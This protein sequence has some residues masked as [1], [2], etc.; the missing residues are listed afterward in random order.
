MTA[1]RFCFNIYI[2]LLWFAF[3]V[4]LHVILVSMRLLNAIL[5]SRRLL[6]VLSS[7]F[8]WNYPQVFHL[9]Q[10]LLVV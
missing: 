1:S 8:L 6:P 4:A 3:L 7:Q 5:R 9:L 2:L 10:W